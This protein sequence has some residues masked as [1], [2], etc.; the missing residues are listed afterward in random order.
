MSD[1][2]NLHLKWLDPGAGTGN[3]SIVLYFRLLDGLKDKITDI[4]ERK[5]YII[6]NMIYIKSVNIT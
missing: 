1:F 4:E 3:Y 5:D 6:E 2:T